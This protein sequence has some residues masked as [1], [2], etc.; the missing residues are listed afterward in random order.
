MYQLKQKYHIFNAMILKNLF[1]IME[2]WYWQDIF[3]DQQHIPCP[4][5]NPLRGIFCFLFHL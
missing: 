4:A 2:I 1:P 5:I 3:A